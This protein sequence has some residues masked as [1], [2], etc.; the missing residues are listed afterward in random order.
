MIR[1]GVHSFATEPI[2]LKHIDYERFYTQI[3]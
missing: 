3:Q 2:V 1:F